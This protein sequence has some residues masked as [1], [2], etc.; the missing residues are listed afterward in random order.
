MAL[1]SVEIRV[2]IMINFF[3]YSFVWKNIVA[4]SKLTVKIFHWS[5]EKKSIV[6]VF[7]F[8]FIIFIALNE[9]R[10]CENKIRYATAPASANL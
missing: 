5:Y 1:D 10:E 4:F 7:I 3:T 9:L 8:I 2:P 6:I